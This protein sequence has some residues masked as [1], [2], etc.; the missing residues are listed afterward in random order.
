MQSFQIPAIKFSKKEPLMP[1]ILF[2]LVF[3]KC[4]DSEYIIKYFSLDQ[5]KIYY[6]HILL[7]LQSQSIFQDDSFV[8]SKMSVYL[9]NKYWFCSD[10]ILVTVLNIEDIASHL[11]TDER[12]NE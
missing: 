5:N 7:Y 10:Y 6:C 3:L 8:H 4:S 2:K 12:H 1:F 9:L 11:G